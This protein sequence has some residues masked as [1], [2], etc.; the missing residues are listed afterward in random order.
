VNP[1]RTRVSI[2]AG[3]RHARNDQFGGSDAADPQLA[4]ASF[5]PCSG[6]IT[7]KF[8]SLDQLVKQIAKIFEQPS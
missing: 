4:I 5:A 3:R 7:P 8:Y 1:R 6:R 2:F